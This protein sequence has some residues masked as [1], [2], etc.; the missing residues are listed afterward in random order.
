MT[1]VTFRTR[2]FEERCA[3]VARFIRELLPA[4]DRKEV[5][6]TWDRSFDWADCAEA[7]SYLRSGKQFGKVLLSVKPAS[8]QVGEDLPAGAPT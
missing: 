2:T 6:P 5:R 4:L 8:G 3:V 7:E 1:G